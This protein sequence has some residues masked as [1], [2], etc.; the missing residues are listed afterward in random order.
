[1]Y[2]T[3]PEI[4]TRALQ[5]IIQYIENEQNCPLKGKRKK[6]DQIILYTLSLL[7]DIYLPTPHVT[8]HLFL[9][10]GVL[11]CLGQLGYVC[12]YVCMYK[13]RSVEYR[14]QIIYIDIFIKPVSQPASP[15]GPFLLLFLHLFLF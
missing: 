13:G 10:R 2:S 8:T 7:L 11:S 12:M 4:L 9:F 1:M 15:G 5:Y 14:L 6:G 3:Y